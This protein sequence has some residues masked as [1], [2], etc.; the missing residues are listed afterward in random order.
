M[1]PITFTEEQLHSLRAIPSVD[2]IMASHA[3]TANQTPATASTDASSQ[4]DYFASSQSSTTNSSRTSVDIH[5]CGVLVETP[6]GSVTTSSNG[7]QTKNPLP[8]LSRD[9]PKPTK[10]IDVAEALNRKPGRWTV[11]GAL[12][13]ERAVP[14]VDEDKAKAQRR[15]ALEEAKRELFAASEALKTVPMPAPKNNI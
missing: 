8:P 4:A 15:K 1:A 7:H 12:A 14:V 10:E 11:Q 3:N 2:Y 9:F 5:D 6:G 13:V